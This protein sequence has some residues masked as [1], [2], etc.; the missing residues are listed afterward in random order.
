[1]QDVMIRNGKS[2]KTLV[3]FQPSRLITPDLTADFT[4]GESAYFLVKVNGDTPV[5]L[6]VVYAEDEVVVTTFFFP[7]WNSDVIKKIKASS[8]TN[9]QIGF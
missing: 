5:S 1:M 9:I 3:V 8:A 4:L 2:W 6:D 7:G